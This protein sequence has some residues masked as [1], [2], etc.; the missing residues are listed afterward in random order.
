MKYLV[1]FGSKGYELPKWLLSKS[2]LIT[3]CV[4][5]VLEWDDVKIRQTKFY[6]ENRK[7]LDQ[8][9]GAGYWMWKPFIILE[10]L[11]KLKKDDYLLYSDAQMLALEN[12]EK[13]YEICHRE[14]GILLF[15]NMPQTIEC[16]CK[17]DALILSGLDTPEVRSSFDYAAMMSVWQNTPQ[18]RAFLEEWLEM[19][20]DE[21]MLTD[22]PNTQGKENYPLFIDHRHDQSLY[23]LLAVKKGIKR[24]RAPN[25]YGKRY[26]RCA[27]FK[28]D[29]YGELFQAHFSLHSIA[30]NLKIYPRL[31]HMLAADL[32]SKLIDMAGLNSK[33]ER[34]K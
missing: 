31:L 32:W 3:K 5:K 9:R 6:E 17:R 16:W 33:T 22:L 30:R 15:T 25:Q 29:T 27:A 2:A 12:C 8:K 4:D 24:H 14:N 18:A 19:C 20:K 28:E 7:I 23:S 26:K 11:K 1:I 21:R 34:I 13:L 10:E